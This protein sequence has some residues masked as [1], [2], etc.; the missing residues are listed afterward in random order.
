MCAAQPIEIDDLQCILLRQAS[1]LREHICSLI[2]A[3]LADVISA[4]DVLQEVWS[5][6]FKGRA[7]LRSNDLQ[8]VNAWLNTIAD[9]KVLDAIRT[10]KAVKRGGRHERV[11]K[12]ANRSSLAEL[13]SI[14]GAPT[15]TPSGDASAREASDAV[16]IALGSLPERKREAISLR[17]LKG[18]SVEDVAEQMDTTAGAVRGL[19]FRGLLEMR[20]RMGHARQFF[21]DARTTKYE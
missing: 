20:H 12:P 3:A 15:P 4:D 13:V 17:Y 19:V 14:V 21:S 1:H 8:R 6:A 2:P 5:A 7:T 16:Q 10:A 11:R 9:R 18:L